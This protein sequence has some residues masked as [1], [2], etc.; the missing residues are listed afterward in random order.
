MMGHE[1]AAFTVLQKSLAV[2]IHRVTQHAL[3]QLS[4]AQDGRAGSGRTYMYNSKR[5]D[6]MTPS[7][8]STVIVLFRN[9]LRRDGKRRADESARPEMSATRC[10]KSSHINH[11]SLSRPKRISRCTTPPL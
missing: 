2:D 10:P 4:D 7:I 11:C 1:E 3:R 6:A 5:K 9:G 8:M